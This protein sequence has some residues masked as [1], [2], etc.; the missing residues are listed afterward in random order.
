M[1]S[2]NLKVI[3][4]VLVLSLVLGLGG[5]LVYQV[6]AEEYIVGTSADW[7]PFELVDENGNIVGF[8]ADVMRAIAMVKGYDVKIRDMSFDALIPA[9]KAGKVDIVAAG[10]TITDERDKVIDYTNPYWDANQGVLVRKDSDLNA[11]TA[12]STGHK[13]GAQRGTTQAGWLQD[14]LVD[15]GVDVQLKLYDTNDL[16][17]MDL[18]NG[19]IDS[20]MADT[21]AARTFNSLNP[22]LKMV[23]IVMTG[24][25]LGFAVQEGDPEGLLP[26]LDDG[27]AELRVRGIYDNLKEAYFGATSDLDRITDCFAKCRDYLEKE[28]D[29]AAYAMNLRTCMAGEDE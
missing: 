1:K 5:G 7:P 6:Q 29:P 8:D 21:P 14:N 15:E 22:G 13:V 10:L 2:R 28:E 25:H 18:K 26:K 20:F 4:T 17:I 19:R 11:V 9:L 23:G 24:E 16:A 12:L 27:L 3:I